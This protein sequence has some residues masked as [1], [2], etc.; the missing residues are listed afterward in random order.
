L[1]GA[2]EVMTMRRSH[3]MSVPR[4]AR[5][6]LAAVLLL[7]AM[8][9]ATAAKAHPRP[10]L[11]PI[12][13]FPAYHFT[14]LRVTV[15][16]QNV[17]PSC[18]ASGSF[19][20]WF[21]NDQPSATFSQVCRDELMTLRY[22]AKSH[23]PMRLRFKEQRGVRVS[24]IDYGRTSS[25]PF[26]EPMYAALLAAGYTRDRDI[27]V[28]GYDARLTPDMGGFLKRT[29]RL[30]ERTYRDN[31]NRPVHLTGHSNGPIYAE[32]LLTHTSRA[33]KHKYIH[34][35]SPIAGNFPGQGGIWFL[36]FTGLNVAD[37]TLPT[38]TANARS[39]ALM[40]LSAPSTYLSAAD[41]AIFGDRE[42]VIADA[43]TDRAYA[44]PDYA[45]LLTDAGLAWAIPI[46]R[47]Y[48]GFLHMS[49]PSSY[50]GVD[51]YAEKG[52]GIET[53]VG[54][55]LPNLIVGQTLGPT[56]QFFTRDGDINQEDITND[57]VVAWS[58][59]P[60]FHFSLTD[61]PGVDHFS[62]PGDADVLTRLI[63]NANAPR[64]NC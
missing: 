64:S 12:V 42:T 17:D 4:L 5:L 43:S 22:Q 32:Y 31:G 47:R 49:K 59:M 30:I 41:P 21:P 44:P 10:G 37:F 20:D 6:G 51:V 63:A 28:A 24:I 40:Y 52:S 23:K 57:A 54:I 9:G 53:L 38:S 16:R 3:A 8:P 61:N 48:V 26:Y 25:A 58:A 35:F 29:K 18:P 60:C 50:P 11:T 2:K 1:V 14:K 13:L 36:L 7:G 56:A 19:E 46:A 55:G 62:L 33:W 15:H 39:S 34:G 27:R 45:S